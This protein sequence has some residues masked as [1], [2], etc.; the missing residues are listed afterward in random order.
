MTFRQSFAALWIML[1]SG[2]IA[3]AQ[4]TPTSDVAAALALR[5][6]AFAETCINAENADH[7]LS[8]VEPDVHELTFPPRFDG[9]PES[10]V[11]LYV[12]PCAAGAYNVWHLFFIDD[13]F[14]P[15]PAAFAVPR[16]AVSM[17]DDGTKLE[18]IQTE[19]FAAQLLLVNSEFDP[20]SGVVTSFA[21]SRGLGDA[22]SRGRW[23]LDGNGFV[24]ERFEI[25]PTLNG[26]IDPVLVYGDE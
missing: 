16:V 13:G 22:F 21:K 25:D 4:P 10:R 6:A 5:K 24:L 9:S 14:G 3:A 18:D 15:R 11:I 23:R 1:T 17:S 20:K 26:E 19:G 2:P 12:M 7:W 8:E